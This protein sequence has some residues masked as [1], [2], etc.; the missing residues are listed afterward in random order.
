MEHVI[1]LKCPRVHP[2]RRLASLYLSQ[3]YLDDQYFAAGG[4]SCTNHCQ[5]NDR[6]NMTFKP[7]YS[8]LFSNT[9]EYTFIITAGGL[10]SKQ[11]SSFSFYSRLNSPE[12]VSVFR[13][14][15]LTQPTF[16]Q[17]TFHSFSWLWPNN[18]K[19]PPSSSCAA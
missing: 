18:L 4:A 19:C 11:K 17:P 13:R 15:G 1:F 12:S 16:I 5:S 10:E 2:S 8:G 14:S 3:K 9:T 6:G 7:E